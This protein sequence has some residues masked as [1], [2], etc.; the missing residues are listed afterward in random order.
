MLVD[1]AVFV[2]AGDLPTF[3]RHLSSLWRQGEEQIQRIGIF[4]IFLEKQVVDADW[5]ADKKH[6]CFILVQ[7]LRRFSIDGN[8]IK[9]SAASG[10]GDCGASRRMDFEVESEDILLES[11]GSFADVCAVILTIRRGEHPFAQGIEQLLARVAFF[12]MT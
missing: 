3:S 4:Q 10:N 7:A 1:G 6:P 12:G 8:L 9:D 2:D 11:E 5:K